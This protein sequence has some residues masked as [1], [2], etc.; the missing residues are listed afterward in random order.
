MCMPKLRI[1][2]GDVVLVTSGRDKG[3]V[4]KVIRVDVRRR[5]VAVEGVAVAKRHVRGSGGQQ[6][7]MLFKERMI[8]VSNVSLWNQLEGRRIKV[9]FGADENGRKVR[10][11]KVS[12]LAID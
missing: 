1:H 7:S 11:D 3:S 6:G 9:R 5:R 12:G 2:V 4:G 8:H 10:I